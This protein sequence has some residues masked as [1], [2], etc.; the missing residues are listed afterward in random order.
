VGLRSDLSVEACP[1]LAWVCGLPSTTVAIAAEG[2]QDGHQDDHN[3]QETDPNL[4][5]VHLAESHPGS[6]VLD[7]T[8]VYL[9]AR[10]PPFAIQTFP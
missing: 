10:G 5:R 1:K 2:R 9:G 8:R 3:D 6:L 4:D 7:E